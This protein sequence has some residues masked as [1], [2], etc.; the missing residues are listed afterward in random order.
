M[1][2]APP[3]ACVAGSAVADVTCRIVGWADLP[4]WDADDHEAA[5]AA[6]RATCGAITSP[7]W[8]R[9]RA[10]AHQ[11]GA[12]ARAF[13][14]ET[15]LPLVIADGAPP[16]FTGYYE[17]E[18]DGA[19]VRAGNFRQPIYRLPP[20][21]RAG[22]RWHSR[23]EIEEGKVL[24]GRGL[25][26]AW[27]R[28]P[29]EAFLLQVQGSGRIRMTDGRVIRVGYAGS[30]GHSY[31]SV[32][33]ELV[34]RGAVAADRISAEAIATWVRANPEEGARLLRHNPSFVFFRE[35]DLPPDLGPLGAMGHPVT[36]LRSVAVDP[37][38]VPLGAPVWI[39]TE[40][41]VPIRRLVVAQDTGAAIRGAQRADVFIGTG[42]E[43]GRIAG[44]M[45]DRGRMA[46]P[47]RANAARR[48]AAGR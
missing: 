35:L 44:R 46:V 34:R 8:N 37:D 11:A 4:G 15:F 39:A 42:A 30:N 18:L 40:G 45:R 27:L 20:D 41:A 14:E 29:V 21:L 5:L 47:F 12:R 10:R 38:I 3:A 36:P 48:L 13:F 7:D 9:V 25:E 2:P 6:F 23:A 22:G 16:L 17:P 26:I 1:T 32:G 33:A 43:A 31:R 24:E 28:D 19:P